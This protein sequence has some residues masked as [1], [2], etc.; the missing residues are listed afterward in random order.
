ML[1]SSK[2]KHRIPVKPEQDQSDV[3]PSLSRPL[4]R[5]ESEPASVT[6][7]VTKT[8]PIVP[9]NLPEDAEGRKSKP[10]RI[11]K[12][13]V[14]LGSKPRTETGRGPGRGGRYGMRNPSASFTRSTSSNAS[15][16]EKTSS[17]NRKTSLGT[18][19]QS[20]V[21]DGRAHPV[22]HTAGKGSGPSSKLSSV[23]HQTTL[24]VH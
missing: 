23:Q 8:S 12:P 11:H 7:L 3:S 5:I 20:A 1:S 4:D 6:P 19:H 16:T 14:G 22:S 24:A 17:S 21:S 13:D 15:T 10:A 2:V 18:S 9:A